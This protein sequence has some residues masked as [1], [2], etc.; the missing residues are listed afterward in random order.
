VELQD[1]DR[2][3]IQ[4]KTSLTRHRYRIYADNGAG[5]PGDL[6]AYVDQDL[7]SLKDK[8]LIYTSEDKSQLLAEF[9]AR[10]VLDLSAAFDVFTPDGALIGGYR[11]EFT[12][13]LYRSTWTLDQESKLPITVLERNPTLA[14]V[15]RAWTLLPTVGDFPFPMRYH[16]DLVR[17]G[18][19]IGAVD[20]LGRLVDNYLAWTEDR[21]LDR[22]LLIS[23][24][25]AL[26]F[27]QGR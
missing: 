16:F 4:Q 11:K 2:L 20:R 7:G 3:H 6:V 12:T 9:R 10:K 14:V 5:K 17:D 25:V 13:S 27:R 19:V 23:L 18:A 26:D 21:A 24:G 15:R 22:R 1:L 8:G